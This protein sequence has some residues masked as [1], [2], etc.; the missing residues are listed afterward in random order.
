MKNTNTK[1]VSSDTNSIAAVSTARSKI[2]PSFYEAAVNST[3]NNIHKQ[4]KIVAP[5]LIYN[6]T[7]CN[8]I[9]DVDP[10]I[11]IYGDQTGRPLL[12]RENSVLAIKPTVWRTYD[13]GTMM[14]VINRH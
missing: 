13:N 3:D 12:S 10:I 7:A 14:Q 8:S 11:D 4:F 5:S 9:A 6:S 2:V 1:K